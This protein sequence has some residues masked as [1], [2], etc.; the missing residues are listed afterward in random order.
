[1]TRLGAESNQ[2]KM[3]RNVSGAVV[4]AGQKITEAIEQAGKTLTGEDKE[5]PK[6]VPEE[7]QA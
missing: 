7:K 4:G 5:Q 1:M 2:P 3:L 6:V